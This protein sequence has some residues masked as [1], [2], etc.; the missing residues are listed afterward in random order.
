M[1]Q[2]EEEKTEEPTQKRLEKAREEG[3]VPISAEV[4][5]VILLVITTI[6]FLQ[7]G[8]WMYSHIQE[9]F[10]TFFRSSGQAIA[11]QD[12]ALQYLKVAAW[13]G[14]T[15]MAPLIAGLFIMAI[16]VNVAQTG[17]VFAPKALEPKP[18]RLN[19]IE[20]F[21]KIFSAR[22]VV[23]MIKGFSK[24][25]IIG[26]IIYFTMRHK[27]GSIVS[28]LLLPIGEIMHQSGGYILTVI[29]RI[30]A[31][32]IVLAIM[33]AAY[34]RYQ[35]RKDL[36][37]TKKEV[38]DE[39]KQMEGDPE[40]KNR[41]K[42]K[43]RQMH[44]K[45]LDH[46]VLGSEVVVTNPTHYAVALHY[47]PKQSEAPIVKA[48]GMRNRALKIKEFA[49]KYDVPIVEN[50]PVARALYASADE[51]EYVP[52][53]LYKAVAEILAYVYKLNGGVLT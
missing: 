20:G 41:R 52:P 19:P 4:S 5:S 23:K 50:K 25:F 33:D 45:R 32:L 28:F 14:F 29:T 16:L 2:N 49:K 38:K 48:K 43:S 17:F 22:G 8:G 40:M 27:I 3:N 34:E 11:N 44:K 30:L 6:I 47:D 51:D 42:E 9:L 7:F 46:A 53:E 15:T 1:A 13:Y 26:I 39:L 37:M 18:N 24:I 36:K 31:A 12:N 21:K 35:H 10:E